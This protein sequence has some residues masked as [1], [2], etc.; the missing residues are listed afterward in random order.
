MRCKTS[1][2]T[3]SERERVT[4]VGGAVVGERA[5]TLPA[6][7]KAW[8]WGSR[9]GSQRGAGG[10]EGRVERVGGKAYVTREAGRELSGFE[11][12]L[13]LLPKTHHGRNEDHEH[14]DRERRL[15]SRSDGDDGED[16]EKE[17]EL[18]EERKR[19]KREQVSATCGGKAGS[20]P[21]HARG[22]RSSFQAMRAFRLP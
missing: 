4:G 7:R 22:S 9:E 3:R 2:G 16:E 18:P 21:R 19:E 6:L 13:A 20:S 11:D 1:P 14:H 10:K 5:R 8:T 15:V 17:V 12:R